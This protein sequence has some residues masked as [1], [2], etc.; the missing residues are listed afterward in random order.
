MFSFVSVIL[1][2][3]VN[4]IDFNTI[5]KTYGRAKLRYWII[6][7]YIAQKELQ[8]CTHLILSYH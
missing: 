4:P 1:F 3:A 2:Q 7:S 5:A 8:K 6:K